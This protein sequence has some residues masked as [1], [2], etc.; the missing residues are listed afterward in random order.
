MAS[1]CFFCLVR[2]DIREIGDKLK[3]VFTETSLLQ[4]VDGLQF[5]GQTARVDCSGPDFWVKVGR[6]MSLDLPYRLPGISMSFQVMSGCSGGEVFYR[7][8]W[9]LGLS[10]PL[11]GGDPAQSVQFSASQDVAFEFSEAPSDVVEWGGLCST[12]SGD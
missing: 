1:R 4:R 5:R 2:K 7:L 3:E 9:E 8:I 12:Q 10:Q 6:G 11:F